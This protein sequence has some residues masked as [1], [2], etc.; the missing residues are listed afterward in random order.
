MKTER[1]DISQ[2]RKEIHVEIPASDVQATFDSLLRELRREMRVPGFRPGKA[3]MQLVRSRHAATLP[4]RVAERLVESF[5]HQALEREGIEPLGG[6]LT[7]RTETEE[8]GADHPSPAEEGRPYSFTLAMQVVPELEP[9]GYVGLEISRP[10]VSLGDDEVQA[11][12]EQLR[13][14]NAKMVPVS[15]RPSSAPDFVEVDIEGGELGQ[16]PILPRQTQMIQ[17]GDSSNLPDFERGL[18]GL[19]SGQDFT[20]EVRYPEDFPEERLAKR[21]VY[22]RGTVRNVLERVVPQLD[23][24]FARSLADEIDGLAGLRDKL[25][26]LLERRKAREADEV[27][28]R[29][30]VDRLLELHPSEAPPLLIEQ[31]LRDRLESIGRQ[32]AARGVD[33]DQLDMDWDRIVD[34]QRAQA[35][36]SVQ[37]DLLLD[38][39]AR[40]E[41]LEVSDQEL[42][43]AIDELAQG[44]RQK[45]A[46]LRKKLTRDGRVTVLRRSVLRKKC[47][48]W[49]F[50]KSHIC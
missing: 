24:E 37:S 41:G 14:A 25:R 49:L 34:E 5:G 42:D 21:V 36:R 27:A 10:E 29:R 13:E 2:A 40:K 3:P 9:D 20:F 8:D 50:D 47:L 7:L 44:L 17:L 15:G 11:E 43:E 35:A 33:P 4:A 38:A 22:Y 18:T 19:T 12:L 1:H 48:D 30:L 45:P 16:E 26:E 28:K 31:E 46:E 23:D 39:I 32:L 6:S